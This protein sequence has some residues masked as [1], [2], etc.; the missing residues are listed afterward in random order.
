MDYLTWSI[1][2]DV[3][4]ELVI[5]KI[6]IKRAFRTSFGEFYGVRVFLISRSGDCIGAGEAPVD[7]YPLY[8][9]EF[10]ESVVEFTKKM[11]E[12]LFMSQNVKELLSK[13]NSYRGNQMAKTMI[14]YS[15][16]T[17][18]SC[19]NNKS[20]VEAVGGRPYKLPVQESIGITEDLDELISCAEEALNWGA[21]RLKVKIKPGWD[22][23][24]LKALRHEFPG[25]QLLAD[26]N[27]A[28]DPVRESHREQLSDVAAYA[29]AIEQP[30]PPG[31]LVSSAKLS[32]EEGIEVVLDES[33]DTP[34]RALEVAM[35]NEEFGSLLSIN[36]KPP[37]LGGL[38]ASLQVLDI[39]VD[40]NIPVFI[41]G[42][43]ETVIGRSLNMVVASAVKGP[44][45]PSDFSPDQQFYERSLAKDPFDIKCGFVE[46][47][48]SPGLMFDIDWDYLESVTVEK[49][50]LE[51]G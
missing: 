28:Y 29:D 5:A 3:S 8:S 12:H 38:T 27:G 51:R 20:L 2:E 41:G 37:R 34:R 47:R 19:L 24:P 49:I 48:D 13:L 7:P 39:A 1:P 15:I 14:E 23:E 50:P 32:S 43:L 9:G 21:R 22:V 45:E 17:L 26:A 6:P 36:V 40:H 42:L 4:Y 25:V 11:K 46:L 35:L 18:L 33:V 16:L 30:Y 10:V 31:D 44:L